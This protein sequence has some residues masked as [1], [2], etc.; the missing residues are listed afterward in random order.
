MTS[1]P[2][3]RVRVRELTI[4]AEVDADF[5]A[6][7][8]A[9]NVAEAHVLGTRAFAFEATELLPLYHQQ[10]V[11]P[12]RLFVGE[13]DGRVV[14]R[15]V[16]TWAPSDAAAVSTLTVEVLPQFRGHGVGTA[17]ADA[18]EEASAAAGRF[19][20]QSEP[21]HDA[22][23]GGAPIPSPTGFGSVPAADPGVRFL[24]GRGYTLEQVQR[25]SVLQLPAADPGVPT[26]DGYRLV[27]WTGVTPPRW[28]GEMARMRTRM[29]T[30][31]PAAGLDVDD[32]PWDADRVLAWDTGLVATGRQ[33]IFVAAEHVATGELAGFTEL[34][35][36]TD[37]EPAATQHDTI[38]LAEHRGHRLGLALKWAAL[39]RLADLSPASRLVVTFNAEENRH[40]LAVNEALGFV[41]RAYAGA[42]RKSLR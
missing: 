24:L 36:P 8:E 11:D 16:M 5:A 33:V 9:R 10:D 39:R 41:P 19:V 4:P 26:A 34:T 27:D 20:A 7:T 42:W 31:A 22:A 21:I 18:V 38:V 29:V 30:D 23:A 35:F 14:G 37:R 12:S 3:T 28:R 40:M 2:T 13:L 6:A 1:I 25:V 15:A 32:D 17:L